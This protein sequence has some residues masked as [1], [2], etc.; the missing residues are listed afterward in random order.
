MGLEDMQLGIFRHGESL[1]SQGETTLE[2]A[3]DLIPLGI[4]TVSSSAFDF[5]AALSRDKGVTIYSS[6][7]GRTLHTAKIISSALKRIEIPVDE[8]VIDRGL[9]EVANFDW[10]LFSPLI[11]GGEIK[12]N[13]MHFYIDKKES[14][15]NGLSGK[16]YLMQDLCHRLPRGLK[17]RLP[18]DYL[19]ALDKFERYND[20]SARMRDFL[21]R[22]HK[23]RSNKD[24]VASTH[25]A[26]F[27][28]I[29]DR[30][31]GGTVPSLKPGDYVHLQK[32]EDGFSLVR[33]QG[34]RNLGK[35]LRV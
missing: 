19:Q 22:M 3:D 14:N 32:K 16:D 18:S 23:G 12:L 28:D 27:Y 26:L 30:F 24:V 10:S 5:S 8:I 7:A 1:Y 9:G 4:Q 25:E 17:I 11:S 15:P 31:S 29:M 34:I 33:A 6:P 21:A 20:V 2:S 13:G 35:I